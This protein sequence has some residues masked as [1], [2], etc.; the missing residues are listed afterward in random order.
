[1]WRTVAPFTT[2]INEGRFWT[3]TVF[4]LELHFIL[5]PSCRPAAIFHSAVTFECFWD[6]K[7]QQCWLNSPPQ[8][9]QIVDILLNFCCCWRSHLERYLNVF[10][11]K[12]QTFS[13]TLNCWIFKY[14]LRN[15]KRRPSLYDLCK[16][17]I[18]NNNNYLIFIMWNWPHIHHPACL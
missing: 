15:E 10:K 1:M 4:T 3:D 5:V 13:S 14:L 9:T 8:Q 17:I 6:K 11:I 16:I 18:N 12:A 7:G 2:W